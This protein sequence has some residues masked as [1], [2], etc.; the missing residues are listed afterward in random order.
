MFEFGKQDFS[1]LIENAPNALIVAVIDCRGE[2]RYESPSLERALGYQPQEL[3]GRNIAEFI[4]PEDLARANNML[5]VVRQEV[6]LPMCA[7]FRFRHKDGSWR[8]LEAVGNTL[9]QEPHV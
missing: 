8:Y 3:I 7:E 2:I 6:G 1:R 4:H 9:E 5:N